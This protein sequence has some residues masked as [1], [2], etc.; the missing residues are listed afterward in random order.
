MLVG[1]T[2]AGKSTL[3][4]GIVNYIMG[5][6]WEDEFRFKV[7]N[8]EKTSQAFSQ[9]SRI[10]A[11][12][13]YHST[14][15]YTLTVI[16]TPGFGDTTGVASDKS[17]VNQIQSF[18]SVRSPDSINQIHGIGF[19]IQAPQPRLTATMKYTFDSVLSIFG[20]DVASN[21]FLLLTFADGTE[22]TVLS[23][24]KDAV[25]PYQ[26]DFHFNNSAIYAKQKGHNAVAKM[27][28]NLGYES[29]ESFFAEFEKVEPHS[30]QLT[31]ENLHEREHLEAVVKGLKLQ[32]QVGMTKIDMLRQKQDIL[33]HREVDIIQNKY[34]EY[35]LTVTKQRQVDLPNNVSVT[36][37][38][39]C[40]FTCHFPCPIA[41]DKE[42][43]RCKAMNS[44]GQE[45]AHCTVCPGNCP[46]SQHVNASQR[47]ELYYM[48]EVHTSDE[49]K[50]KFSRAVE[51]K[52]EIE[53]IISDIEKELDMLQGVI[54]GL[55]REAKRS[56]ER[57]HEVAL[58]PNPLS[59]IEYID[60]LIK[61]EQSEKSP[62]FKQRIKTFEIIK[63]MVH[64][65]KDGKKVDN[66]WWKN[67]IDPEVYY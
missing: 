8:E 57:L 13:I 49:L 20:K 23:A 15:P 60:L 31:R 36:N 66:M 45:S 26:K 25:I 67:V 41:E 19:V 51:G 53:A 18:F 50:E 42:K 35:E 29:F 52:N 48:V 61:D 12:S 62:G 63:T 30:L 24:I 54:I 34:F 37:C 27:F 38:T 6:Q 10:T 59:E 11:Y 47:F 46:W 2:G 55:V 16:D 14:L 40:S 32:I 65:L 43:Y 4:N 64:N 1:A 5:V 28:W 7:V 56:L 21:I 44:G 17:I 22:P 9:T 33:R 3:I 58:K 39:T